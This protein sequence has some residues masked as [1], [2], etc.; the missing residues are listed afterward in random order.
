MNVGG[1]AT[2]DVT[3]T[4]DPAV[5]VSSVQ[6]TL[7]I[8]NGLNPGSLLEFSGALLDGSTESNHVFFGVANNPLVGSFGSQMLTFANFTSDTPNSIGMSP[9][10]VGRFS[11]TG[12]LLASPV[13]GNSFVVSLSA[14]EILDESFATVPEPLS[15]PGTITVNDGGGVNTIP[16]PYSCIVF[17]VAGF[18]MVLHGRRRRLR[19]T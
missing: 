16:E 1:T 18:A 2:F 11:V 3:M 10:L 7:T 4:A 14:I 15:T 6:Y 8:S 12:V 13:A 9:Q 19:T 17:G 5:L